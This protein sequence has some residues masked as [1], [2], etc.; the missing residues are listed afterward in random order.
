M[1]TLTETAP[2]RLHN[3]HLVEDELWER[4]VARL[5]REHNLEQSLAER[6][7][8]ETFGFIVACGRYPHMRLSPSALVDKGWHTFILYTH[9]Y[10]SFCEKVAG[11]FVHHSPN[12]VPGVNATS[13][14]TRTVVAMRLLGPVDEMLW[15]NPGPCK[16]DGPPC[17]GSG[18]DQCTG[19]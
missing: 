15:V 8:N 19:V 13:S 7:M 6:V 17:D 1:T 5:V 16:D 14:I 2:G 18:D 11:R 3:R 9:E 10:T 12:D 4:L